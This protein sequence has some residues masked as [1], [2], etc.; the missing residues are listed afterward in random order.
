MKFRHGEGGQIG[1]IMKVTKIT[2]I[3]GAAAVLG[4]GLGACGSVTGGSAPAEVVNYKAQYLSDVALSN[5]L[6]DTISNHDGW[7]SRPVTA[8]SNALVTESR[9]MLHQSWPVSVRGDIHAITLA[10]L[11]VH[12][13]IQ[14]K[15][16]SGFQTDLTT[17]SAEANIV[18]AELGLPAVKAPNVKPAPQHHATASPAPPAAPAPAP[19][20]DLT[21]TGIGTQGEE[22]Y[23][24]SDTSTAF[25]MQVESDYWAAPG[26]QFTS[27]SPTTGQDYYMSAVDGDGVVTVT[28]STGAEV[29]FSDGS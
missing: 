18:R 2:A 26:M 19:V 12:D 22:V 13:D 29:Q 25:A 20:S 23:S 10:A 9:T 8:Y 24:N 15:D 5:A 6:V 1:G 28:N 3:A 17:A 14:S 16:S 27:Y 4:L 21:P 7:T 11:K